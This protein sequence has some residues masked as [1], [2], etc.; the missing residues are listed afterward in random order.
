MVQTVRR[1]AD[2]MRCLMNKE[3]EMVGE[4]VTI[5]VMIP[6]SF[7]WKERGQFRK[8]RVPPEN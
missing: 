3:L 7:S 1:P 8:P 5:L 2:I 4:N 6:L